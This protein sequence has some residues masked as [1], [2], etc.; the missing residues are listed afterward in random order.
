MGKVGP[1]C[2]LG[3]P[4]FSSSFL[5]ISSTRV[6]VQ[7]NVEYFCSKLWEE[8]EAMLG[9]GSEAPLA[10]AVEVPA[11]LGAQLNPA[12]GHTEPKD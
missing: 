9:I 12:P 10:A 1:L 8:E 4:S 6:G 3:F 7:E 5:T 2:A 11:G